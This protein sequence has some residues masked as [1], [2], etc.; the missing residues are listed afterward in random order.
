MRADIVTLYMGLILIFGGG[1]TRVMAQK[2]S[3]LNPV[4]GYRTAWSMKSPDTWISAN[5]YSGKALLFTG[6]T[7][8]LCGFLV[9]W[10][11][12]SRYGLL[13]VT[14]VMAIGIVLT[15]FSTER[16][17]RHNFDEDGNPKT[18]PT[19]T[20]QPTSPPTGGSVRDS[21]VLP[22]RLPFSTLDYVLE[23]L[24]WSGLILGLAAV[25]LY[26]P[27]LPGK[28]PQHYGAGGK[29]DAWGGKGMVFMLP[30]ISLVLYGLMSMLHWFSPSTS[31]KK[32]SPRQWRLSLDMIGWLKTITVW[33]FT[34]L[35]WMTLQIALGHARSLHAAF[36]PLMLGSMMMI[37]VFYIWR[38]Q[39]SGD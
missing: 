21:S 14:T 17:L 35:S 27:D 5:R 16:Y 30:V 3:S 25:M 4:A 12:L 10:E 11:P 20:L 6:F 29:V 19:T 36:N 38:I 28:I 13:I 32:V 24:A 15:I 37:M 34:Y 1:L 23:V 8:L 39:K 2:G 22:A 33:T 9:W 26:Y 18:C 7:T 31:G